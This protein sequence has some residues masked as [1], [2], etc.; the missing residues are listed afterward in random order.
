[1][2][3]YHPGT[4]RRWPDDHRSP[5]EE[6][7]SCIPGT[8]SINELRDSRKKRTFVE[9]DITLNMTVAD[10]H[11]N[12]QTD[13]LPVMEQFYTIQGEGYHQGHAAYFI[14]LGGCDVGCHWCD[15]K[16][17]WDA[18]APP[19]ITISEIVKQ[20]SSHLGPIAVITNKK[21]IMHNLETLTVA[22]KQNG[23]RTHIETSGAYPLTGVWDWVCLS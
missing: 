15:V 16:E 4:R 20:A 6:H 11:I 5:A 7:L 22:L 3:L 23:F 1:M 12:V 9:R 14:R 8:E 21:P 17:S 19:L 18:S 2:Q 10:L 13:M